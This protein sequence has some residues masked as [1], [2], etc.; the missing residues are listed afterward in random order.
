[1]TYDQ[2]ICQVFKDL[3]QKNGG[4][5]PAE[6]A[7]EMQARGWLSNMDSVIDIAD[8]MRSLRDRGLL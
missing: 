5:S 2:K 4:A 8:L 3:C 1:M 6:V 7:Q